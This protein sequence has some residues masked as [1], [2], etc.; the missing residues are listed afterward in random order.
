MSEESAVV[1]SGGL[2]TPITWL[3][4]TFTP[5]MVTMFWPLSL[6][7]AVTMP[8]M[9]PLEVVAILVPSPSRAVTRSV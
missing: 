4:G 6:V 3:I 7:T 5:S 2:V 1:L 8:S 9:R